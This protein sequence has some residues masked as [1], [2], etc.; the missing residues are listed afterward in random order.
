MRVYEKSPLKIDLWHTEKSSSTKRRRFRLRYLCCI[1]PG[2]DALIPW[3]T[4]KSDEAALGRVK[5]LA[6]L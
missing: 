1:I 3:A 4:V 5:V 2:S 6:M